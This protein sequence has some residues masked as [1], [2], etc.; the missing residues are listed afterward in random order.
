MLL[1]IIIPLF[2]D[3][4]IEDLL[5]WFEL[6]FFRGQVDISFVCHFSEHFKCLL[7]FASMS[8]RLLCA[9]VQ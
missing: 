2:N 5:K 6:P 3:E 8:Q 1:P 4:F 7:R 9:L